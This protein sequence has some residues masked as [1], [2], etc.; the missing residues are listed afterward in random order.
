MNKYNWYTMS[1]RERDAL[2]AEKVMG[3]T[4]K[5][6]NE[7]F[8]GD[9]STGWYAPFEWGQ[10]L[11]E[12]MPSSD[13]SAAWEAVEKL[14][15]KF[16]FRCHTRAGYSGI[17]AAFGYNPEHHDEMGDGDFPFGAFEPSL[18][19]AICLAALKAVGVEI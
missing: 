4:L 15:D 6:R 11:D 12:F 16:D 3:W 10:P 7:W 8:D 18:P 2:V 1:A 17:W 5:E 14:N 19:H 13:I 9:Q